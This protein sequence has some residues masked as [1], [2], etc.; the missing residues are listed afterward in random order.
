MDDVYISYSTKI[1]DSIL[2]LAQSEMQGKYHVLKQDLDG[3]NSLAVENCGLLDLDDTDRQYME[4]FAY[5]DNTLI[6]FNGKQ[7]GISCYSLSEKKIQWSSGQNLWTC[8]DVVSIDEKLVVHAEDK[9]DE[10]LILV[11]DLNGKCIQRLETDIY[12]E[13]IHS[14][15][16]FVFV[17]SY[18]GLEIFE[19]A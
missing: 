6:I 17:S 16:N 3:N 10:A 7:K 14:L 4:P 18:D 19:F 13:I 5:D 12:P 15:E 1:K 2:S 8:L 11:Y 9:E